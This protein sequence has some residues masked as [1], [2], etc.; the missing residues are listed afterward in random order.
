VVA[1]S[2]VLFGAAGIE[3]G[4][5]EILQGSVPPPA[6][7]FSSWPD[8]DFLQVLAGEPAMSVLPDLRI[9]GI[10]T[11]VVSLILIVW[12]L[13]LL[14]RERGALVQIPLYL[15][16]LLVGGGLAPPVMGII[17]AAIAVRGEAALARQKASPASR[18]MSG[19]ARHWRAALLV[20]L[21]GYFLLLPGVPLLYALFRIENAALIGALALLSF[22][23]LLLA[24]LGAIASD[25]HR[26]GLAN[27]ATVGPA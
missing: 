23:G 24:L 17:L 9:T 5:G 11:I 20:G 27:G 21:L 13:L 22:G 4:V 7:V 26:V 14:R 1:V 19:L 8:S 2:G 6:L 16:L 18:P 3:H 25:L 10:L 12:S 15:M